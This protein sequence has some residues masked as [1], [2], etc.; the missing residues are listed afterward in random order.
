ME[1]EGAGWGELR[2][3]ARVGWG[4]LGGEARGGEGRGMGELGGQGWFYQRPRAFSSGS[5]H[6]P[7]CPK[8]SL[9]RL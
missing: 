6:S 8:P 9:W 5:G 2:G 7:S 1:A 3:V 4:E